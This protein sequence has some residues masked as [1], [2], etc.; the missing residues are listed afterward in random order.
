MNAPAISKR[1]YLNG[2]GPLKS[3]IP[4]FTVDAARRYRLGRLREQLVAH[5]C[6]AALLYDPINIRYALDAANMQVWTLHNAYR[7]ALIFADGP[8][9]LFEFHRAGH[10]AKNLS[11]VSEIRRC[12]A[13]NYMEAA[14][15]T[16][17]IVASWAGEI[18]ELM[19]A[20]GGKNRRLA[21]DKIEPQGLKA[22]EDLGYTYVEGQELAE[23]ARKI[24]NADEMALLRWSI[25]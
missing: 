8:A 24:K 10:L 13:W 22:L 23:T 2:E 5:D 3:P 14:E 1:R 4:A 15:T 12:Q 20:H 25:R 6:A 18:D 9:I 21:I 16:P 11:L 19:R 17:R 7:Y